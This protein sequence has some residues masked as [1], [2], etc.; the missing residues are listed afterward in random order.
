MKYIDLGEKWDVF[1]LVGEYDEEVIKYWFSVHD[2]E[3]YD[4][5]GAIGSL[6][7][8]DIGNYDR[9]FCSYVCALMIGIDPIITPGGLYK[10]LRLEGMIK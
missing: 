10:K 6:F 8:L 5:V 1:E 2:D 3:T 7:E 9:K 4:W